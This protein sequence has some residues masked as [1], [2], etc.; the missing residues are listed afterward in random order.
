MT[1]IKACGSVFSVASWTPV[2]AIDSLLQLR[3][4]R[5]IFQEARQHRLAIFA[6]GSSDNHSVRLQSTQLAWLQVGDKHDFASD[7]RFRLIRQRDPGDDLADL[8]AYVHFRTQQAVRALHLFRGLHQAHPQ[9]DFE[10]VVNADLAVRSRGRLSLRSLWGWD[11][12]LRSSCGG[13]RSCGSS[14]GRRRCIR[15]ITLL[16]QLS[17]PFNGALIGARE[18]GNDLA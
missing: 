11:G 13:R 18:Y 12:W 17:H 4:D 3:S 10:E 6:N 15:A 5:Y 14:T 8:G 16:F 9:L 2:K 1:W 7:Q